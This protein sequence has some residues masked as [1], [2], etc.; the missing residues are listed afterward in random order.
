MTSLLIKNFANRYPRGRWAIAM[1]A[2]HHV[3]TTSQLT[4]LG[5]WYQ[6]ER[7]DPPDRWL[8]RYRPLAEETGVGLVLV[9]THDPALHERIDP[10]GLT[11]ATSHPDRGHPAG[12]VWSTHAAGERVALHDL[13]EA[14]PLDPG[15]SPHPIYDPRRPCDEAIADSDYSYAQP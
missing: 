7:D 1:L 5:F 14:V 11:I 3:L 6:P 9:T 10:G 13:P 8:H 15:I 12:P 2:E 4:A